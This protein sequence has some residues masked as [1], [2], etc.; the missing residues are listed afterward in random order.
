MW[1][2]TQ[3]WWQIA[4]AGRL[5]LWMFLLGLISLGACFAVGWG[6]QQLW[7]RAASK[8]CWPEVSWRAEARRGVLDIERYLEAVAAHRQRGL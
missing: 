7:L 1:T 3:L 5:L 6:G 2:T 4:W 8:P